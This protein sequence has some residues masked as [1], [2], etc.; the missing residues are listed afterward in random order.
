MVPSIAINNSVKHRSFVYTQLNDQTFLFKKKLIYH[1]F[2]LNLGRTLT[3]ATTLGLIGAGSDGNEGALHTP[4]NW[5]ITRSSPSDCLLSYA[6]H[7]LKAGSYSST[8]IQSVN[9][10]APADWATL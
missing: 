2:A 4:I 9:C 1:L 7:S 10:T 6:G 5:S 3:G 8:E